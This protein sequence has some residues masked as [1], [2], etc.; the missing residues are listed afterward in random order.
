MSSMIAL[1]QVLACF[2]FGLAVLR[3]LRA[4]EFTSPVSQ[5]A[6]SGVIGMG[7]LGWLLYFLGMIDAF[8]ASAFIFIIVLGC[9]GLLFLRRNLMPITQE[10]RPSPPLNTIGI[11]LVILI[12]VVFALD[13]IEALAPS[14]DADSLAYHYAIPR[15][16]LEAGKTVFVPRAVDGAVPLLIQM[17]YLPVLSLG[18]EVALTVWSMLSGYLTAMLIFVLARQYMDSTWSLALVLLFISTPAVIYGAGNGQVEV[19]NAGFVVA[20]AFAL[21]RGI[22][23]LFHPG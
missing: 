11:I 21:S 2:G 6:W 12:G 23:K 22:S 8:N 7:V 19:R 4:D 20:S 10:W 13:V 1:I 5:L 17:T 9:C 14:T 18:G 15:Q 3:G 16:F